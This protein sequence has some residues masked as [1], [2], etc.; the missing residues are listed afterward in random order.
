MVRQLRSTNNVWSTSPL[1][2]LLCGGINLH[3]E[4]HLFPMVSNDELQHIAPVVRAFAKEHGL[5]YHVYSPTELAR[6][7]C[8]FI[9]GTRRRGTSS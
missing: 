2:S 3:I 5:P 9:W 1:W 4:H 6:E 7:H 8:A